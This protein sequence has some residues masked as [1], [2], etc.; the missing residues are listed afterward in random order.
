MANLFEAY[1][2]NAPLQV[3]RP[4]GI[5]PVIAGLVELEAKGKKFVG[6]LDP[7]WEDVSAFPYH[8]L[9]GIVTGE[10][11]W[12]VGKARIEYITGGTDQATLWLAWEK[13]RR[14]SIN[15]SRAAAEGILREAFEAFIL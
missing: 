7:F 5:V 3:V 12:K 10:G 4:D 1:R 9:R 6:H 13:E 11:P 2:D 15:Y 8:F 14:S